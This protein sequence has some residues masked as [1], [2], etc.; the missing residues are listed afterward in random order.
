MGLGVPVPETC[1]NPVVY[2]DGVSEQLAGP[3]A[4]ALG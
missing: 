2:V 1:I 3:W 4:L